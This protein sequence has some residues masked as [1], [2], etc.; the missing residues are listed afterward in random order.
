MV[1]KYNG[2]KDL[3]LDQHGLL[4]VAEWHMTLT[5]EGQIW[6]HQGTPHDVI[7]Y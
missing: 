1:Y 5:F 4:Q 3:Y 6:P 7:P 2:H